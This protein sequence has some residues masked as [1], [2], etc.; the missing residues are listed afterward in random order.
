MRVLITGHRGFLGR[1]LHH[2][3]YAHQPL[4]IDITDP[5]QPQDCREFFR[6]D[7]SHFDLVLHCAA[8]VGGREGIDH[9]A[10]F[11]AADNVEIDGAMWRWA[12][13]ARPGRV[14]YFSSAAAYPVLLQNAGLTSR[15]EYA[16]PGAAGEP[17][18]SYGWAKLTG[19]MVAT[20][21]RKAGVPVTVIRPFSTYGTDQCEDEYPF[22]AMIQRALRRDDPFLVWGDG[23][24]T[25]DWLHV[26]DLVDAIFALVD[27]QVDGPVNLGTGVGTSM[28]ELARLCMNAAG[29]SAPI[30]HLLGK[31]IG[32]RYRVADNTRLREFYTPRISIEEGVG[33]A[34]GDHMLRLAA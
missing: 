20:R 9:N 29:Y 25:R 13:R 10:A 16:F 11:L 3:L 14:V 26:D 8:T 15:E 7:A 23:N 28:D 22:P 4:C 6:N 18:E 31:P 5:H 1:H 32:V 17:D 21:V 2:A 33:R 19:E 34:V 30:R 27:A 12:L 24:Q